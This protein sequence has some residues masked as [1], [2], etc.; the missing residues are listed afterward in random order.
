MNDQ[1]SDERPSVAE[2]AS[3]LEW[4]LEAGV[5]IAVGEE[6]RNWLKPAAE[7]KAAAEV[8]ARLK[9]EATAA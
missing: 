9:A 8:Y 3:L 6:P 4:W 1:L 7:P 2:A 5:D